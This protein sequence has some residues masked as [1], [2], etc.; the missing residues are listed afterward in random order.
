ML[1]SAEVLRSHIDYSAWASQRLVDAL[2]HLNFEEL[3]RDFGTADKSVAGT[4]VHTFAADR[5]WMGRIDGNMPARFL[6]LEKDMHVHVLRDDWPKVH[7]RWKQWA[8]KLTDE[9]TQ[10]VLSYTNMKGEA[11][12]SPLWQ[13]VLHVVN[14]GTHHRGQAAGFLRSM[15][16]TPPVLD[17]IAYYR[18]L[19]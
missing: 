16:H 17:L 19:A 8:A 18:Q 13:V 15:G 4:L 10:S 5:I 1:V 3:W 11:F 7:D 14:H 12:E 6:D 2:Q 9:S